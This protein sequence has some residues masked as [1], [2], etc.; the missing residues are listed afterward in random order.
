MSG[1]LSTALG[2]AV[3]LFVVH[4]LTNNQYGF[5]RDELATLDDA[6]QLAWG[7]VAYP[8]LT[9]AGV[10]GAALSLPIAPLRS[11]LW[12]LSSAVQDNFVEEIGW[13]ELVATVAGIYAELPPETRQQ[14]AILAGNYGEAGAIDLYGPAYGLPN[15]ISGA[16]SY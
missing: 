4:L 12:V 1:D 2:L 8:P 11:P 13:P 16:D 10:I 7:Y 14:T 15:A 9:P 6:H 3:A 5:H